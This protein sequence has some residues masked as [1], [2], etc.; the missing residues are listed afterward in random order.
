MYFL[1]LQNHTHSNHIIHPAKHPLRLS[2]I[3]DVILF[4][5]E[6]YDA[7]A[8]SKNKTFSDNF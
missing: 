3:K 5:F 6:F 2:R 1:I 4:L 7:S 8:S